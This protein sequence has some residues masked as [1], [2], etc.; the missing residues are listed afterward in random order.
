MTHVTDVMYMY[1]IYVMYVM[2]DELKQQE[3]SLSF[4]LQESKS[5]TNQDPAG[6]N[7]HTGRGVP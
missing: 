3:D 4:E 5:C 2:C 1:L 7:L 6:Q